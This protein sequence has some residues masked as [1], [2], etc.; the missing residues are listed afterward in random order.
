MTGD[1]T[2]LEILTDFF[3]PH[4][5]IQHFCVRKL[6]GI[7]EAYRGGAITGGCEAKTLVR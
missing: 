4:Y 2:K 1:L 3:A 6:G 7:S 5:K